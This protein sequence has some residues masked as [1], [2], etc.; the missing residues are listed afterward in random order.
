M[1]WQQKDKAAIYLTTPPSIAMASAEIASVPS[2]QPMTHNRTAIHTTTTTISAI[3]RKPKIT[4]QSPSIHYKPPSLRI[5]APALS[6]SRALAMKA[7]STSSSSDSDPSIR[8][9]KRKLKKTEGDET[10]KK[11][12]MERPKYSMG[13]PLPLYHPLGR[14]ALSLPELDPATLGL[15]PLV[16]DR[17]RRSSART[18]RPAAKLREADDEGASSPA[19]T[20]PSAAP[21]EAKEKP[22]PKKKGGARPGAGVKRKRKDVDEDATYPAKKTRNPR[23]G[24]A[25]TVT[26]VHL[27]EAPSPPE[28]ILPPSTP[29]IAVDVQGEKQPERRST[30]SRG[31]LL[32]RDSSASEATATSVSV[33]IAANNVAAGKARSDDAMELETPS[34]EEKVNE[35]DE[36]QEGDPKGENHDKDEEMIIEETKE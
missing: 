5:E 14:L 21:L 12:I 13:P 8:K 29:D 7:G 11:L 32:R 31:S 20:I 27:S 3:R 6:F 15:P 36:V 33:S 26:R 23:G 9:K 22:S 16:A 19:P 17:S 10:Q 35:D 28:I 30:R 34:V 25:V 4:Y 18:R 24:P 1:V 2:S